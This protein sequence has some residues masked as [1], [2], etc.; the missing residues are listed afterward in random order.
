VF[1]RLQELVLLD[2]LGETGR[3]DWSRVSVDSSGLRAVRG[4]QGAQ[5]RSIGPS[6][7]PKLHLAVEGGRL[8][9]SLLVTGA[10]TNDIIPGQ[11]ACSDGVACD[12]PG[13]GRSGQ[14]HWTHQREVTSM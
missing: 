10:N 11:A 5:T 6:P 4:G 1:E 12:L 7:G 3:L 13:Q 14:V 2:E 9:L 8:P